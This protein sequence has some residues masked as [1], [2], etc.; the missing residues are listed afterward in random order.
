MTPSAISPESAT[1]IV[2]VWMRGGEMRGAG[3]CGGTH[4]SAFAARVVRLVTAILTTV[5]AAVRPMRLNA[6]IL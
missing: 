3:S 2:R 6:R 4:T 5:A 1:T